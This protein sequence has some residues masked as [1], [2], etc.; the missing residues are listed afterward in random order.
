MRYADLAASLLPGAYETEHLRSFHRAIFGDVYPWAGEIRTVNLAKGGHPFCNAPF[1]EA[2]L[3]QIFS[4]LAENRHL[5]GLRKE[6]FTLDFATLYGEINA[7]HPFREGNGR[8]QRAFLRQLAAGA[9]WT[10]AWEDLDKEDND[11]ACHRYRM[12]FEPD[13][14]AALLEPIIAPR[15]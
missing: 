2:Q 12:T 10:I 15:A 4:G 7:I 11:A 13:E 3:Y 8:S 6:P 5:V 9:G 14:L 1:I